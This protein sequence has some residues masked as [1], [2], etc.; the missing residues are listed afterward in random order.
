MTKVMLR[1]MDTVGRQRPRLIQCW[2]DLPVQLG[3]LASGCA[4]AVLLSWPDLERIG[5]HLALAAEPSHR[6]AQNDPGW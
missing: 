6:Q 3:R 5:P 1:L 2:Q 4:Q